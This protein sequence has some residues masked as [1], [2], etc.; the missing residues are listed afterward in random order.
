MPLDNPVQS[1]INQYLQFL[2]LWN[3][4]GKFGAVSDK[5]PRSVDYSRI[6]A[7]PDHI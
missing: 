1:L 4:F 5:M 6:T 2:F 3:V 7:I